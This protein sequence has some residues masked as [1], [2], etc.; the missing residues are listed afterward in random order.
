MVNNPS[1]AQIRQL[2]CPV[3]PLGHHVRKHSSSSSDF[4]TTFATCPVK[5]S[6]HLYSFLWQ[7][8]EW[9]PT[10]ALTLS[11]KEFVHYTSIKNDDLLWHRAEYQWI[12]T[13]H[14]AGIVMHYPLIF[15]HLTIPLP[16]W[17]AFHLHFLCSVQQYNLSR[18]IVVTCTAMWLGVRGCIQLHKISNH[19]CNQMF[20]NL[21]SCVTCVYSDTT[22]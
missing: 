4:P 9:R 2:C 5:S 11:I 19:V 18:S 15:Y 1:A 6:F 20:H 16:G 7:H 21:H 3:E 13:L 10:L 14:L 22:E 8:K 17:L 12:C